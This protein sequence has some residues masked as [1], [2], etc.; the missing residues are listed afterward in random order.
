MRGLKRFRIIQK[1]PKELQFN[2]GVLKNP[3]EYL[4][5]NDLDRKSTVEEGVERD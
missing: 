1:L 2:P 4:S 3:K 5:P